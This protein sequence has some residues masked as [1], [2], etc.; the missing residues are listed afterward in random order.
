MRYIKILTLVIIGLLHFQEGFTYDFEV[1]GMYYRILSD[2]LV[3]VTYKNYKQNNY[4]GNLNIPSKVTYNGEE[5]VV[6]GIDGWAFYGC[7]G[8]TGTLTLP[9]SIAYIGDYAFYN[10][11]GLT[12]SL[13]IPNSV[14]GIWSHAFE[15]CKGF[16]GT[17]TIPNSV[18]TISND[19]FSGCSEFVGSLIIPNSVTTIGAQAF[20]GCSGFT[21]VLT[22]PN[23]IVRIQEATFSN[24]SGF[25]S[26]E[27]PNTL[28]QID[29]YAFQSC[30]GI[31]GQL[32]L[33]NSLRSFGTSAFA[34]CSGLDSLIIPNSINYYGSYAF[35]NCR[36]ITKVD[37]E[38]LVPSQIPD[39]M[40]LGISSN[41]KLYVPKGTKGSYESFSGWTK[42]F[43]EIV[44]K[45]G[46]FSYIL[47]ITTSGGGY[48]SYNN[49]NIR[50]TGT[51]PIVEGESATIIFTPDDGYRLANVK[52]NDIDVTSN[53]VNNQYT[54]N[55]ISDNI[56]L[57][58]TFEKI[59][60]N[61]TL[62]IT[63][64]GSGS[65]NYNNKSVRGKTESFTVNKGASATISFNP[66]S[67]YRIASVKVDDVD[68]TSSVKN[69]S[70]TI[71]NISA[72]TAL[73]VAFVAI[74]HTL[75]I[76]AT[77]NGSATYNSTAV[78]GKTQ[79][80]TVN[81][82]ASATI[83]FAPDTGY[84]IASVKINGTDVTSSVTNNQYIISS[85][86][87]NTT[88][89]VTFEAITH[90]LSITSVG[91][92]SASYN[93]TNVR[94]NSQSF[95]IDEGTS[96]T[97]S[98]TPDSGYR[99]ASVK[100][101]NQD[102]T[103]SVVNN[104]YTISNITANT[105]LLVTFEAIPPTTYTLSIS[106]SGNGSANYSSSTVRGTTQSF[107][108]NEG[109]SVTVS[110]TPDTGCRIASVKL[111]NTD[112]TSNVLN[113]Q[114]TISSISAN[115]TLSVTFEAIPPTT[116]TL[117]MIVSGNGSVSYGGETLRNGIWSFTVN[118][119]SSATVLFTP[120]SG[121]EI[122]SVKVNNVFVTKYVSNNQYVINNISEYTTLEVTFGAI[123][124]TTYT[125]SLTASGNGY[126]SYNGM[127]TRN[128]TR[129]FT[130]DEGSSPTIVVNPDN[131][132]RVANVKVNNTDV[133]A[134]VVNNQYTISDIKANTTLE[135][136]F[137][138]LPPT[139]YT[140][141][142]TASGNGYASYNLITIR[143]N[144]STYTVSE[145][146]SAT[147][148]FTPDNGYRV[149]N[150]KVN[151]TDVT[152]SVVN[153]QY[154]ISNIK[155]N[156]TLEVNFEAIPPTTYTLSVKATGNGTVLYDG[157]SVRTNTMPFSVVEGSSA[158]LTI[159]ADDG[160]R[161]KSVT[162]N[163][164]DVTSNVVD[165]KYTISNITANTNV[166][167]VFEAIPTYT[168]TI[169][170]YGN[171]SATYNGTSIRFNII[172]FSVIE[173]TSATIIFTP[174]EGY[175]IK[176]VN[177]ND[178]DVTGSVA[179]SQYTISDIKANTT[180]DV[181]FE[182]IP[183]TTY[184]LSITAQ[185]NGSAVFSDV[186][187]KNQ[188][189]SFT[190]IEG[191]SA[192]ITF[193]PESGNSINSVKVNGEDVT[194]NISNNQYTISNIIA[195]TTLEVVFEEVI[196]ALTVEGVNFAVTSQEDK[197]LIVSGGNYGRVLTV[198]AQLTSH[199]KTW[200]VSGIDNDALK[201]NTELAAII[202]NAEA[203]FTATVNN[204]NLLLYVKDEQYAQSNAR[205]IVVN[206]TANSIVLVEAASGNSFYCPQAFI[207]RQI[208]FTHNY[209]MQ[210]GINESKGWETLALPFDVQSIT[211]S[212]KG[213][214]VP[215][216][217]WQKDETTR[218]FWLYELTGNGFVE[219]SSIKAYT[220]YI[221]SMPNHPQYYE[222][223]LLKGHV[224]FA[225][226]NVT[227]NVTENL[228][229]A[230]YGDRTFIPCFTDKDSNEGLYAL[231][232]NNEYAANNSGMTEGS[233]FVLNMR[234]IHP[235]E[236]YMM[237]T[238]NAPLY[239]FGIFEGMPTSIQTIV[240]DINK[241][242][243]AVYDLQGR[244]MNAPVKKGVYI[245]NGRKKIIK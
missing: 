10:C 223:W 22:I 209:Q 42:Y 174:D 167:V 60:T 43:Q 56:T 153:N 184:T 215:F 114:Y 134:N 102:V 192:T 75:S 13:S 108:V 85:I 68:I 29:N 159:V 87:S 61:Y 141:S 118:E 197:T 166:E 30:Y 203:A 96:A 51:F 123:P 217:G 103:S 133:T 49:T 112:V 16:N 131:G 110:F 113:N 151:N 65:A 171:G 225:A 15:G 149:A 84:R 177:V 163:S 104:Q 148:T 52:V 136:E 221:I 95:T 50:Y 158:T 222:Q 107:P 79:T 173:S 111:N 21:G 230:S 63:S 160:N 66:D 77:G 4:T 78:R 46:S 245:T 229:T 24:C 35:G 74:T 101:N 117:R 161:I 105:T 37:S 181:R 129:E 143:N 31:T 32:V 154:T 119:G 214:I 70:Y 190:V 80:F 12:G 169:R 147:I 196:T 233:K 180:L 238:S 216:A 213:I 211:H 155:A 188:T 142:V 20:R 17:L 137:E 36:G 25:T 140:L 34:Q 179:N 202:W 239:A 90:T 210:T 241:M 165:G 224:T 54:I 83:T 47:R 71:S 76:S 186:S 89:T 97:I 204:P 28:E 145:G 235:F 121:Y 124:P 240:D 116:Y 40:F 126:A 198:P 115:T 244:K 9:E 227:I 82:G 72:N 194:A 99:I 164:A 236:A 205:N 55:N 33:P 93:G 242:R 144:T 73:N 48:A 109:T 127:I 11:S 152:S 234:K 6:K 41:A 168:L 243:D 62:S 185:G 157:T 170:A 122:E 39:N 23:S 69:N 219:T 237:T 138:A 98:F 172:N 178:T 81:E 135:V 7:N 100:V 8:I 187:V 206:G 1:N 191:T 150:V 14:N 193:Y 3:Y 120:D 218:P 94:G 182:E 189:Q 199:G 207:A 38:V 86:S 139:T 228:Q 44:E 27:L 92:G 26:L 201:D 200:T 183:P 88:L 146:T 208:S 195:N 232:V 106:A 19:A 5:D 59:P 2:N 132:Y 45:E 57:A 130:I 64:S 156:T 58:V 53:V 175:R 128:G 125:L 231:N 67:G 176:S 226:S 220:P 91:N 18:K 162:V 212:E